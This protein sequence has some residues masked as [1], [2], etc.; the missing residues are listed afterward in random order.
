MVFD[1]LTY[2]S[3]EKAIECWNLCEDMGL[4]VEEFIIPRL[5]IMTS[6]L[7]P[8]DQENINMTTEVTFQMCEIRLNQ[9]LAKEV[10]VDGHP[11]IE[12]V[13]NFHKWWDHKIQ[14]RVCRVYEF[15]QASRST[16]DFQLRCLPQ[17]WLNHEDK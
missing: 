9:Q 16:R 5:S 14:E 12:S 4:D 11:K 10:W 8:H 2:L 15:V 6:N 1:C 3:Y 13:E 17:K 7:N